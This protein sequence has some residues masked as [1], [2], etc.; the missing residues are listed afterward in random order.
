MRSTGTLLCLA[1]AAAFGAMAIFG[2]LAYDEGATVGTLL[3][4]RFALAAA[5]LWPLLLATGAGAGLRA[6]PGRAIAIA[7]GLGALGYAAQA[8]A[9]FAALERIDASLL[10]LLVY[11]F[12]AIVAVSAIALRRERADA[13]QDRR[14]RDRVGGPRP[15]PRRRGRRA[16]R[17]ARRRARPRRRGALQRLRPDRRERRRPHRPAR[18]RD[19]RLHER[20]ADA[21]DRRGRPRASCSRAR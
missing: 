16:A 10:S 8:G 17:P 18:A 11:T 21:D 4:V 15:D 5:L 20:G 3:A 19:A 13:Q 1:S 7:A 14:R 9:Y 6:L 12:P 2:K